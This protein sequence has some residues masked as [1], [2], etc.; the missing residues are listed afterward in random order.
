MF[1][2][3]FLVKRIYER[4]ER[5]DGLRILVD[6]VWPRGMSKEKALIDSCLK[7]VAPST[8]LRKWFDH[9]PARWREFRRRYFEELRTS[10]GQAALEAL[11]NLC[12]GRK[13]VTLLFGAKDLAHNQAVALREY[14]LK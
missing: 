13:V 5:G 7:D 12:K 6:R 8:E 10:A 9:N 11:F 3:E 14:L 1:V 4:P 2:P